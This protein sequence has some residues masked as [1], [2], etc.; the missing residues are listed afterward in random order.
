MEI[1]RKTKEVLHLKK[2][3]VKRL[4][5]HYKMNKVMSRPSLHL[6]PKEMM[7]S[8]VQGLSGKGFLLE[9]CVVKLKSR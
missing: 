9:C 4:K 3:Q 2:K 1:E 7:M 6:N 8:K 5:M